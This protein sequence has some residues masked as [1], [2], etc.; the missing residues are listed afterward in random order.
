MTDLFPGFQSHWIDT[1]IGRIFARAGGSGPPLVLL[2]GFPQSHVMWH[3]VAPE[4]ARTHSVVAMDL[5]GYGWSSVPRSTNGMHYAKREMLSDVIDVMNT[6]GH[7]RFHV[8][9]H[10]RG[11]RLG[12]RL[13]LDHPGHVL[14]LA[15][16]DILPTVEVW[17]NIEAGV[18]PGAHW[19]ALSRPEPQPEK[20]IAVDPDGWFMALMAKWTASQSLDAFDPRAFARYRDAWRDSTR[21][22]AMCE[23][24]RAGAT[25][26]LAADQDDLAT[27]RR[28]GCPTIVLNGD[29][30]LT[31]A[32][33]E[34][35]LEV[36][37]RTFA[38][39][40]TGEFIQSGHFLAEENAP[41]TIRA[42]RDF[43]A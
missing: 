42:L 22:H 5:R 17:K 24:Y 7:T 23:D 35:P 18:T 40:A 37:R 1:T 38:P 9:G 12:Y 13:A 21:I 26:D 39:K 15:V 10:D 29:F 36:W 11:A 34:A 43:L 19:V 14:S 41:A 4:L 16:L 32:T 33:D 8:V 6:L 27:G 31:R 30:Y 3:R 2:H 28:I 20:E 25:L